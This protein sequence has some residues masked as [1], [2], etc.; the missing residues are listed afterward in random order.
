MRRAWR[1]RHHLIHSLRVAHS[2]PPENHGCDFYNGMKRYFS[3]VTVD[4]KPTPLRSN[5]A[6]DMSISKNGR[7][8]CYLSSITTLRKYS[9]DANEGTR[10]QEVADRTL[11][12]A[13]DII[14]KW[15]DDNSLEDCDIAYD[16]GVITLS[17]GAKGT[18]IL[19][20]QSPT[21]QIWLS[22]PVSGPSH[23]YLC[24]KTQTWRDTR[25]GSDLFRTLEN[26][27]CQLNGFEI[28]LSINSYN[29]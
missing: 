16:M 28:D 5:Y 23:Y 1:Q 12:H 13:H 11:A 19:N 8:S 6:Y 17:L 14:D 26:E 22:S 7:L 4:E 20:K 25:N 21:R 3:E 29:N 27:L 2:F 9:L 15:L 18:F 10:F 24:R